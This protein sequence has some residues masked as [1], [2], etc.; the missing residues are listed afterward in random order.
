MTVQQPTNCI[1]NRFVEVIAVN[2]NC[3]HAGDAASLAA[4]TALN[5]LGQCTEDAGRKS[6]CGGRL[7]GG[8]ADLQT[9]EN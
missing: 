8:K 6:S 2:K 5:Q 9:N 3:V 1:G 4:T 7:S